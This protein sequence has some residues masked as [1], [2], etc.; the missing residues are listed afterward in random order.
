MKYEELLESAEALL[1]SQPNIQ[2]VLANG[3]AFL[4]DML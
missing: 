1:K 3:S 4:N 2:S